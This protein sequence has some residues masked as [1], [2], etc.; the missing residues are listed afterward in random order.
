MKLTAQFLKYSTVTLLGLELVSP[1]QAAVLVSPTNDANTLSNSIL[2]SGVTISNVTYNGFSSASGTFSNGSSAGISIDT[3]IILTSGDAATAGSAANDTPGDPDLSALVGGAA[4]N[5]A[6]TLTIDFTTQGGN[7]FFNYVF[8]SEEYNE[9]VN[10]QFNDVFG[11]FLDGTNIALIPGTTTPVAINTVN[12]GNPLGTSAT[13]P[14]FYNNNVPPTFDT[15]YDGF[16]DVFT[17]QASNLAPGTHTIKLAIA[18][19]SDSILDSAVF[20]QGG[21]FGNTPVPTPGPTT[22]IPFDF[23]PGLGLLMLGAW[24]AMAQLKSIVQKS[25]SS[26]SAFSKN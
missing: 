20:I 17:A 22:P 4:T 8:A 25:K 2:G 14:Q 15:G 19:T 18:D 21:S 9:F 11:F 7:L 6:A 3:G 23:S 16:T 13:N 24:G 1:A 26:G 12:G 5:D 10:S